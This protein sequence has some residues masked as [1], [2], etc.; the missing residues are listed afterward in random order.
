MV[1]ECPCKIKNN[2]RFT[3]ELNNESYSKS[4]FC[5]EFVSYTFTLTKKE[6]THQVTDKSSHE[7]YRVFSSYIMK[8]YEN[9]IAWK[10]KKWIQS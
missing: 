6:K 5:T 4:P 9:R 8:G 10:H 2:K 3:V 1:L 7:D